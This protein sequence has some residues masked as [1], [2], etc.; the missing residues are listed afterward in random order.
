MNY[1][2]EPDAQDYLKELD[3]YMDNPIIKFAPIPITVITPNGIRISCN[4][5]METYSGRKKEEII[6]KPIELIYASESKE[7]ARKLVEE[8]VKNGFSNYELIFLKRDGSKVP[9]VAL[10]SAIKNGEGKVIGIEYTAL[11]ITEMKHK[12]K[13]LKDAQ[14]FAQELFRKAPTPMSLLEPDGNRIDVNDAFEKVYGYSRGEIFGIPVE[15]IYTDESAPIIRETNVRARDEGYVKAE[16]MAKR[17]DGSTFPVIV[18]G[19]ALKDEKGNTTHLI[20]VVTDITEIKKANEFNEA[21]LENMP[22]GLT[23]FDKTG[24][25]TYINK[26]VTNQL[27]YSKEELVGKR[28]EESPYVCKSGEPYMKEGTLEAV[29][30]V[31]SD[32]TAGKVS[33]GIMPVKTKEGKI[34]LFRVINIPYFGG[35]VGATIDVTDDFVREEELTKSRKQYHDLVENVNSIVLRLDNK[36]VITFLNRYAEELFGYKREKIIGREIVGTLVPETEN[37]GRSM[38]KVFLDMV[39]NPEKYASHVNENITKDG[40]R[41]WI[42][43]TN[44]PVYD[45]KGN[46]VQILSIGNDITSQIAIKNKLEDTLTYL[47]SIL[48]YYPDSLVV[49]DNKNIIKFISPKFEED[50][51]YNIDTFKG[52]TVDDLIEKI[53]VPEDMDLS[54]SIRETIKSGKRVTNREIE[55]IDKNGSR[56]IGA[57]SGSRLIDIKSGRIIGTVLSIRDIEK[58]YKEYLKDVKKYVEEYN[59]Q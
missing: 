21:L 1:D 48:D 23:V 18:Q 36:G 6:G 40:Q 32:S 24:K 35:T 11:D 47:E 44:K 29:N 59:K 52:L 45:E 14:R 37:T 4:P 53:V 43:W 25:C 28:P 41:L 55:L 20:F 17:K 57:C 42:S 56:F 49:L 38:R 50:F 5:A 33:S 12:E 58:E 54:E 27:G 9:V 46:L 7:N 51:G 2:V 3:K 22:V 16:I 10:A 31:W 19:S 15:G 13:D 34:K 8:A 30:P 39:K 26:E